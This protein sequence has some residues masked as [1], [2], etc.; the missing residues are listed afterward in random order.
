MTDQQQQMTP[1]EFR[2][3][4]ALMGLT[5]EQMAEALGRSVRTVQRFQ[6]DEDDPRNS[7][8]PAGVAKLVRRWVSTHTKRRGNGK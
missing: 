5:Q 3:A 4:R 6:Y 7:R 1:E 8:I 2:Q